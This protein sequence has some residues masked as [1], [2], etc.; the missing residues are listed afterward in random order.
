MTAVADLT[1]SLATTEGN[2]IAFSAMQ[3]LTEYDAVEPLDE[4]IDT[5]SSKIP[6]SQDGKAASIG[7]SLRYDIYGGRISSIS[8]TSR[9]TDHNRT[10][11]HQR[12]PKK[13]G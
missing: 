12:P 10:T 5:P 13:K 6:Q 3:F 4:H 2:Q 7:S 8:T 11:R 1:T 9:S